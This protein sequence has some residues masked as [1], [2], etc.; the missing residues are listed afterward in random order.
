[1]LLTAHLESTG[2]CKPSCDTLR[3]YSVYCG[4]LEQNL[5]YLQG[6]PVVSPLQMTENPILPHKGRLPSKT[7]GM[8]Y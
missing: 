6:L 4:D 1:M 3:R 5:Q 2:Q 7:K 8:D